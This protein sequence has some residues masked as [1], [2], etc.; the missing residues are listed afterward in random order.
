MF[1]VTKPFNLI[2]NSL[3]LIYGDNASS[4][5]SLVGYDY[6]FYR[7]FYGNTN[8]RSVSKNFL[9]ALALS[10]NCYSNMFRDC[11]NLTSAPDLPA[12]TVTSY[13]YY[14]MFSNCGNLINPP[15]IAATTLGYQCC[16]YMFCNCT[17]LVTAPDLLSETLTNY[18]YYYMFKG[19]SK[20][21]YI[22]MLATNVSASGC[23]S[24]WVQD[25]AST[26]TFVKHGQATWTNTGVSGVPIGWE[27]HYTL[28]TDPT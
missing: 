15:T 19:C 14:C 6:A 25:V 12:T 21:N 10:S 5:F 11:S 26:G 17:S 28:M 2:G 4:N 22:K 8:L 16:Y 20:L 3:S 13:G 27:V 7:M 23:L 18:C 1:T 24:Y 9:P